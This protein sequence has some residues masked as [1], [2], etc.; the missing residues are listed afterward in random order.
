LAILESSAFTDG[1]E[2]TMRPKFLIYISFFALAAL[3]I[4]WLFHRTVI[5][6]PTGTQSV[7]ETQASVPATNAIPQI[8]AALNTET[9]PQKPIPPISK[10]EITIASN[11]AVVSRDAQLQQ[12]V[13]A[14]NVPVNFYGKVVDQDN[15][16]IPGVRVTMNVRHSE[17]E[18]SSGIVSTFPKADILT[19]PYGRFEWKGDS[20][21]IIEVESITKEAYELEPNTKRDYAASSGGLESPVVFK[22]WNTNTHEQLITGDKNFQIVPDGRTYLI[23]L[24]K[25][26]ITESGNGDLKVWV[27]EKA[28]TDGAFEW[29]CEVDAVNGGL[30]EE[31]DSYSSMFSAPSGDY[32][33]SFQL[34]QQFKGDPRGESGE[35]RFYLTLKNGTEFGRMAIEIYAPYNDHVPGLIRLQYAINP[36]GSRILR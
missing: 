21:D 17:Y 2:T 32:V 29:S 4:I 27:L 7:V 23:D 6:K 3:T 31:T 30:L 28:L 16:P 25:D 18:V 20:G 12:V 19:D 11:K 24:I 13:A 8:D 26:T 1:I 36:S 14:K 9:V 22:M 33:P 5:S 15:T 34:R 35:R 10:E